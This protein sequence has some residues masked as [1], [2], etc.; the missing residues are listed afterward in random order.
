MPF[1]LFLIVSFL[2]SLHSQSIESFYMNVLNTTGKDKRIHF[3]NN[4]GFHYLYA[5]T[6]IPPNSSLLKIEKDNIFTS[7]SHFPYKEIIT[8]FI[9]DFFYEKELIHF[10]IY[11]EA[12]LL[13]FQLLYY[14]YA[15]LNKNK[16]IFEK[17]NTYYLFFINQNQSDYIKI[18]KQRIEQNDLYTN[19]VLQRME[20]MKIYNLDNQSFRISSE[21]FEYVLKS[22]NLKANAIAKENILRFISN[23]KDEFVKLYLYITQN[24]H[25]ISYETFCK[26]YNIPNELNPTQLM[27]KKCMFIS[28]ITDLF[29]VEV[30]NKDYT[31]S[32]ETIPYTYNKT[33]ITSILFFTKSQIERGEIKKYMIIPNEEA[34]FNFGKDYSF[35]TDFYVKNIK[36]SINKAIFDKGG[37]NNK[38]A[39]I[40]QMTQIC[41]RLYTTSKAYRGE[42]I[43]I[44]NDLNPFL[45]NLGKLIMLEEEEITDADMYATQ[46]AQGNSI[47]YEND[48]KLYTWYLELVNEEIGKMSNLF[49]NIKDEESNLLWK[50]GN[51]NY[52]IEINNID[53]LLD[54]INSIMKTEQWK[55]KRMIE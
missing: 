28:P 39:L 27:M 5:N 35:K 33:N 48:V 43:I 36:V 30:N 40:C 29:K 34:F 24:S 3:S 8:Q 51:I 1:I 46:I 13:S 18:I 21:L 14:Q 41:N 44:N 49:R 6:T 9:R 22:I 31:Y 12:Y 10:E 47:S 45:I 55:L 19:S 15:D 25:P 23:K 17:D 7:C 52:Q 20:I 2:T 37:K 32:F 11:S 26:V 54:K 16:D 4:K 38:H 42:F 53:M 50:M